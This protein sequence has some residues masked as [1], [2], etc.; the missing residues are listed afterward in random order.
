[1]ITFSSTLVLA[2]TAWLQYI[3]KVGSEDKLPHIAILKY[4]NNDSALK[5]P[6][7]CACSNWYV[8]S[9]SVNWSSKGIETW[10]VY[11][12][13][14]ES[15]NYVHVSSEHGVKIRLKNKEDSDWWSVKLL[16]VL[17]SVYLPLW[18]RDYYEQDNSRFFV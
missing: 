10:F 5:W 12:I 8:L 11:A 9:A 16:I 2:S 4:L 14:I 3:V 17:P 6:S 1:M 7:E 15:Q 13:K 18:I